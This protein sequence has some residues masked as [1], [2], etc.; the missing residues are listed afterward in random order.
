MSSWP[1][2]YRNML[3]ETFNIPWVTA[4]RSFPG[5]SG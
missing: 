4:P 5:V 3:V 2:A 1:G